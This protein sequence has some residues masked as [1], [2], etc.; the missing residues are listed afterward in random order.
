WTSAS[1]GVGGAGA[2]AGGVVGVGVGA[3]GAGAGAGTGPGA[4]SAGCADAMPPADT[5]HDTTSAA[6]ER[7]PI[8]ERERP[9]S[10][11]RPVYRRASGARSRAH[12]RWVRRA[13]ALAGVSAH[14]AAPGR[15]VAGGRLR[16]AR[17]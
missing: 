2:F 16:S 9:A 15:G 10:S 8:G 1:F 5:Q 12:P 13:H 7:A 11:M 3:A 4:G 14:D 6:A 17:L